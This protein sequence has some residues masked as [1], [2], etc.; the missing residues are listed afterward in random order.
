[1]NTCP[2]HRE[3]VAS[4]EECS[5]AAVVDPWMKRF[6]SVSDREHIL[7]HPSIVWLKAQVMRNTAEVARASRPMTV[8]QW[9]S[10]LVVAAG[11]AAL[12]TWKWESV[13]ALIKPFDSPFSSLTTFA[14]LLVLAT[15]TV[16]LALTT[17]LAEE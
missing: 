17:I 1:M 6:A 8:V 5:A 12:L 16:T 13:Q 15:F 2:D 4:C 3:F 9:M 11:W 14:M 7:P 10:Y